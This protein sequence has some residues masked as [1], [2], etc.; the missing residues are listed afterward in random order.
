MS[1]FPISQGSENM[2]CQCIRLRSEDG[3]L[4]YN[5]FLPYC[6]HDISIN[7]EDVIYQV[8]M[9]YNYPLVCSNGT[10]DCFCNHTRLNKCS[11]KPDI[12][13][14]CMTSVESSLICLKQRQ[15][16]HIDTIIIICQF[17]ARKHSAYQT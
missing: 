15:R 7:P 3:R 9:L 16:P 4:C 13:M 12:N 11:L 10:F 2:F 6:Y 17:K 1:H 8:K 5:D 14:I